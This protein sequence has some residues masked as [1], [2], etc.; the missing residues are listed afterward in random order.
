L[1]KIKIYVLNLTHKNI[2]K[3]NTQKFNIY[4]IKN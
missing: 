1:K 2:W 3:F 4:I